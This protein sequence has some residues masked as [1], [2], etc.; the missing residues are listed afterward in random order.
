MR[1][2][3][4]Q[5]LGL[6]AGMVFLATP[7][8]MSGWSSPAV[9]ASATTYTVTDL[10]TLG[11]SFS[12][13]IG[14][15]N[16]GE[17]AGVSVPAE[18]TALRG[19]VWE[20]GTMTDL[21]TLG[22][23]QG[24]GTDVNSKGQVAGWADLNIPAP[25]SI[26]NQTSVFCNPPMVPDEPAVAC[27]AIVWQHG[28][29]TDLG[30]LG[31]LNSAAQNKGL[32]SRGDVVGVS[33]VTALDPTSPTG[34]PQFHAFLW[35][36]GKMIDLGSLDGAP[37]SVATAIND[38]GQVV[39]ISIKDST[40][41]DFGDGFIWQDGRMRPLGTLGGSGVAPLAINNRGQ[42]V[43]LAQIPGDVTAHAF[44]WQQ[45]RM[46][47]LG[48]LPGDGFSEAIDIT[49]RGQVLGTSCSSDGCRATLWDDQRVVDINTLLPR[50][51]G[52][53][54]FDASAAN[55]RG[56]IV[57]LGLHDGLLHAYLLTPSH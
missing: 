30:T 36:H 44:V 49:D 38:R 14:L 12:Q 23:P 28:E 10:G 3:Y 5:S 20:N 2:M 27:H 34:S 6:A 50:E 55:S 37:D 43:G 4:K 1:A 13:P 7:C 9:A 22:G 40:A 29:L 32:N 52:W 48:T 41:V 53:Q 16:R 39:G 46:I 15:S 8:L 33:E 42:V 24:A 25:P 57:G 54:L 31:G 45:G 26:F 47:D 17:V 11:G 35:R 51:S 18:E 21:G 19:F 56:Q